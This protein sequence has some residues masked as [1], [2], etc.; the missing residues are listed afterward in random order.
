MARHLGSKIHSLELE[1]DPIL[2][3]STS[4]L[5]S[6]NPYLVIKFCILST[7]Y[8][9]KYLLGQDNCSMSDLG[10]HLISAVKVHVPAP[11]KA[12]YVLI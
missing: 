4:P 1:R 12:T 9:L 11:L 6:S 8:N 3:N 5:L 7:C 2:A 10:S